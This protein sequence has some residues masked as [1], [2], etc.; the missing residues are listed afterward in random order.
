MNKKQRL[1]NLTSRC[2]VWFVVLVQLRLNPKKFN[3]E[4]QGGV[5]WYDTTSSVGAVAEMGWNR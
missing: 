4:D 3:L 2:S 1:I 5:G